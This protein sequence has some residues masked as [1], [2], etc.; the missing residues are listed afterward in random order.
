MNSKLA[1]SFSDNV[2]CMNLCLLSISFTISY[3][4][5]TSFHLFLQRSSFSCLDTSPCYDPG[6]VVVGWPMFWNF[7]SWESNAASSRREKVAP[8]VSFGRI[9]I[10]VHFLIG[11]SKTKLEGSRW[12]WQQLTCVISDVLKSRRLS[13]LLHLRHV[14]WSLNLDSFTRLLLTSSLVD[15]EYFYDL[16]VNW[17]CQVC[18]ESVYRIWIILKYAQDAGGLEKS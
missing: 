17:Y 4:S 1:Q 18:W 6:L 8:S 12:I 9:L 5:S 15:K 10:P 2:R 11:L 13:T 16:G 14:T 3:A 7:E